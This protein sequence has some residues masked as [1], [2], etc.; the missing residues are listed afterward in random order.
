MSPKYGNSNNIKRKPATA[1]RVRKKYI[2]RLY[3]A[4]IAIFVC[5]FAGVGGANISA[6]AGQPD[7]FTGSA[8]ITITNR[9]NTGYVGAPEQAKCKAT[10][11]LPN[12]S[13]V[14]GYGYCISGDAYAI[15]YDGTYSYTATHIGNGSY[16]VVVYSSASAPSNAGAFKPGAM[17]GTQNMGEIYITY[18]VK[19][20]LDL[21]KASDN[22][23]VT[24]G[25][26][27][28]SLA[29]AQYGIWNND[30]SG[31]NR[32][33]VTDGNGY[34]KLDNLT[35]GWYWVHE[36]KAPK[37]YQLD[38]THG[39]AGSGVGY[40]DSGW[41][42]V[43]VVAGENRRINT[44]HVYDTPRIGK[45]TVQKKDAVT[46]SVVTKAG[47][48]F[49][50]LASD[51]T[52]VVRDDQTSDDTGQVTF[53]NL[54]F[55]TYYV[56]ETAAVSP[57]ALNSE[58]V[59]VSVSDDGSTGVKTFVASV[60]DKMCYGN[61]EIKKID[62]VKSS[63]VP[64]VGYDVVAQEDI[65]HPD[66]TVMYHKGEVVQHLVTGND[67]TATT[68]DGEDDNRLYIGADGDGQ[69]AF[70]ETSVP[71]PLTIDKTPI[72]FTITYAGDHA[73]KIETVHAAQVNN[74]AYGAATINKTDNVLGAA[75]PNTTYD[76]K[77]TEDITLWNGTVIYHKGEKVDSLIT[78][79]NG[80]ATTTTRLYVGTDGTGEY[81]L[82]ETSVPT[83]ATIKTDPIPFTITYQDETVE[84]LATAELR[85]INNIAY[86]SA[87]ITKTDSVINSNVPYAEFDV[88]ATEDITL[89]NG[90]KI[91]EQG[92]IIEHVIT[93]EN[94]TATT[95]AHYYVGSDGDGQYEF[96]ETAVRAPLLLDTT[97]IPFTI[98]YKD[99]ATE[100]VGCVAKGQKNN[101]PYAPASLTKTDNVLNSGVPGVEYDVRAAEDINLWNGTIYRKGQVIDHVVTG[102]NGKVTST[103]KYYPATSG[104]GRYE[105]VETKVPTGLTLNSKPIP[106]TV[107]Y[108]S[109]TEPKLD[110]PHVTQTNNVVY[111]SA[112][113]TKTDSVINSNVPYA[114]FD[115]IATE[116]ITLWNGHRIYKKN[117]IIE[118]VITGQDGVARTHARYYVGSDGDG[119]YKFVET[120]VRAPLLLDTTPI[121]FTITY[122][123]AH[124]E[125]VGCVAKGQK[126]DIPYAPASLTKTDN[127]L[128]S[129]VPGVEY[130]VR[131]AEDINL[132]N[133]T[134]Y[135]RGQVLDHVVTDSNGEANS[136]AKYYPGITGIGRYEFVE[137]KVPTG[138]TIDTTPIPFTVKY[139]NQTDRGLAKP[140]AKQTNNVV[141]GAASIKKTET[142][143]GTNISGAEF[144]VVAVE[145][146]VLWNNNVIYRK[147]D[148]VEH[149]KTNSNGIA[150]TTKPLYVGSNGK[151]EYKFVETFTPCPYYNNRIDVPFTINYLDDKTENVKIEESAQKQKGNEVQSRQV[152]FKKTDFS[153][154]APIEGAVFELSPNSDIRTQSGSVIYKK[155]QVIGT[156]TTDKNGN[157]NVHP[158]TVKIDASGSCSYKFVEIKAPKGYVIDSTP[159]N[160]TIKYAGQNVEVQSDMSVSVKN[161]PNTVKL[162]KSVLSKDGTGV[163]DTTVQ[164]ATFRL[165]NKSDELPVPLTDGTDSY[166]LRIDNGSTSHDVTVAIPSDETKAALD[167][168]SEGG[169]SIVLTDEKGNLY[170]L[171]DSEGIDLPA[172]RY[173]VSL[174]DKDGA[175]VESFDGDRHID[176]KGGKKAVYTVSIGKNDGEATVA[177]KISN[178][179]G[180]AATVEKKSGA[181]IASG[182]NPDT[183]YQ[184]EVDG[185]IVYTFETSKD[186]GKTYYG[187]YDTTAKA[188]AYKRQPMLL[189]SDSKFIDKFTINGKDYPV[190][191]KI[192]TNGEINFTHVVPGSYGIGET[193]VPVLGDKLPESTQSY[194]IST[195]ICYFDVD[196]T[197]GKIDGVSDF[198]TSAT[199]DYTVVTLSKVEV[200]G[201]DEIPGAKLEVHDSD[202][203]IVD[204]WTS[205]DTPHVIE[206]LV[207]SKY[208]LVERMTPNRYD[209]ATRVE[210][211]VKDTGEVQHFEMIDAP[212]EI[213]AQIDKRQEIATPVIEETSPNGDGKNKA[214]AQDNSDGSFEY[215]LDYRSTSSTWTDEFTVYDPLDGVNAGYARLDSIMTAQGFEDYDG[216]MNVWYRTN[217]TPSDYTGDIDKANATIA[218]GHVNPWI[219]GDTRG[220]DSLKNDPDGD[221]RVIDYTGWRLWEKDVPTTAVSKL[222]V[223]DLKLDSDEYVTAFRFEYG[224]VEKG[225]TTRTSAWDRNELKDEHDDLDNID[226]LHDEAFKMTSFG[227]KKSIANALLLSVEK[228]SADTDADDDSDDADTDDD[229]DT[230]SA[231]TED[232]AVDSD[233]ELSMLKDKLIEIANSDDEDA[234]NGIIP[235]VKAAATDRLFSLIDAISAADTDDDATTA[236]D[237]VKSAYGKFSSLVGKSDGKKVDAAFEKVS[238]DLSADGVSDTLGDDIAALKSAIGASIE[239]LDVSDSDAAVKYAPAVIGMHVTDGYIPEKAL[240]NNAYV[241][242]YRNGGGE[243]LEG[244]DSDKVTQQT[245]QEYSDVAA[246]IINL[247]QTGI[248]GTPYI[249][250]AILAATA[251]IVIVRRKR[252]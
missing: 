138:L 6:N 60:A 43:E 230:D 74:V 39:Q 179:D 53:E 237:A 248:D 169:Y 54:G 122:K 89:W 33:F 143:N 52:T 96:V 100:N 26:G 188:Y 243:Q 114:E 115:V 28:Y 93:D 71:A 16:R 104:V 72:P 29:G 221:G 27:N 69:Y 163:T 216:K 139:K 197:T 3:I 129:G 108:K 202:G 162:S 246:D 75:I 173:T 111:G 133:G 7:S 63:L 184:V 21:S 66:G 228:P 80:N 49:R 199:N 223:A 140:H 200:T 232:S 168:D 70:V 224:R 219:A 236:F 77:A 244:H 153:N 56:Q 203:G 19:G 110:E 147:G 50:L 242:A 172:S 164:N 25:N 35:P 13:Q 131:A 62:N 120:E 212:I 176:L 208:S 40:N 185:K 204:S 149:V 166:A 196:E 41:Y 182:L 112:K 107:N 9:A 34:A 109:Q 217:K 90:H 174:V 156:Y 95:K 105:F 92:Q 137:T 215:S 64:G 186:G 181:Y 76:V 161:R 211:E 160:F 47:F 73:E 201:G 119:Q 37:G 189:T 82:T 121:P 171:K 183:E 86:G 214:N 113:I 5:A 23:A 79:E 239:A 127:V 12:G 235:S 94:G 145:N 11:T 231:D 118:H 123:D 226:Y 207:P 241:D 91:Y 125:D 191:M 99:A 192:D 247:V 78:D 126:N 65:D 136:T 151:G 134:I 17:K 194:L 128:N 159:A 170:T 175:A 195:D 187:R 148:V 225:F 229:S 84:V 106:F 152:S 24:N 98:T 206:R 198:E 210:F 178:I 81:A 144:D 165:W 251:C 222:N 252:N 130:D 116:D 234:I 190:Q 141:Y 180:V 46:D 135:R 177:A 18:I 213:N 68:K 167:E 150:K 30:L 4:I 132:W 1:I 142:T 8:Y 117:Q 250:T 22:T 67:G 157:F 218:D 193:D 245:K 85:Q 32:S 14:V 36:I 240:D 103:A 55:G 51:K 233:P 249:V 61:A 97:P 220:E 45:I 227:M 48:K 102:S 83:G 57:F 154:D 31:T 238:G 59:A 88:I 20:S 155:N 15:P 87:K 42:H 101:I 205:T 44:N 146:V 38:T 158:K 10:I 124:T 2:S 58:P 209:Q